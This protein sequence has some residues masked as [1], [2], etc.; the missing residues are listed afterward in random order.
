MAS[1]L[2]PPYGLVS[3][4]W[5]DG[6]VHLN[7]PSHTASLLLQLQQAYTE[8]NRRI[9]EHDKCQRKQMGN[10]E[11]TLHVSATSLPGC[12]PRVPSRAVQGW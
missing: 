6:F 5:W 8:L 2:W 11:L 3:D 9:T 1:G 10:A 4:P 7:L 12:L